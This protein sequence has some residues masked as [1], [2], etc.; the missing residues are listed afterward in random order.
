MDGFERVDFDGALAVGEFEGHF[1]RVAGFDRDSRDAE[2][3]DLLFG[4]CDGVDFDAGRDLAGYLF[5]LPGRELALP[6]NGPRHCG[7][8]RVEVGDVED[9]TRFARLLDSPQHRPYVRD[10]GEPE[11]LDVVDA[12][13]VGKRVERN[14]VA[15]FL[16][17]YL[18]DMRLH[19]GVVVIA[20]YARIWCAKIRDSVDPWQARGTF[21][22]REHA[23]IVGRFDPKGRLFAL[24]PKE[25]VR[26]LVENGHRFHPFVDEGV[27]VDEAQDS[28]ERRGGLQ[29]PPDFLGVLV[30]RAV[31]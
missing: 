24:A 22:K 29:F 31:G 20:S 17:P 10:R 5:E 28:R 12:V 9:P 23:R 2:L 19:D 14:I 18:N 4:D 25:C 16:R 26:F 3:L 13:G 11:T 1:S 21:G 6:R 8:G 15:R 7:P 27:G 30:R